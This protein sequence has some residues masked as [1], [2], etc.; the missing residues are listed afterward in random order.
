MA[1]QRQ[2][3]FLPGRASIA[4]RLAIELMTVLFRSNHILS[5]F[6]RKTSAIETNHRPLPQPLLQRPNQRLRPPQLK[7]T[8]PRSE[9]WFPSKRNH[10]HQQRFTL[11]HQ[12]TSLMTSYSILAQAT[13]CHHRKVS[14]LTLTV[15]RHVNYQ[16]Q[17]QGRPF[18]RPAPALS[19]SPG[20]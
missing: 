6:Y 2:L 13:I 1:N 5:V 17:P 16:Q 20:V 8:V 9:C 10:K 7:M 18:R 3:T 19:R 11:K 4:S 14:L 15:I 12:L